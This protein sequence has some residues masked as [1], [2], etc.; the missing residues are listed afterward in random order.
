MLYLNTIAP[1]NINRMILFVAKMIA[2]GTYEA[3]T[4]NKDGQLVY[5][6][7]KDERVSY[8][9]KNRHSNM[10]NDRKWID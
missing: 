5:D 1:D 8:F 9:W 3:H 10:E 2:D 4:L 6:I 7:S